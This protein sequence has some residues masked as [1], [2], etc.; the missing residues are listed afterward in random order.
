MTNYGMPYILE[1]Q[2]GKLSGSDF[3]DI[4]DR[5]RLSFR[6]TADNAT[7]TAYMIYDISSHVYQGSY[8]KPLVALDFGPNNS[9]GTVT[10]SPHTNLP[11]KKYLVKSSALGKSVFCFVPGVF[12]TC[13]FYFTARNCESSLHQMAKNISGAG[14]SGVIK[15]GLWA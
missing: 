11:M 14:A 13:S 10:F 1:D 15:N 8:P 5:M 12:A 7:H 3:V 9:L 2:T 6:C 4:H